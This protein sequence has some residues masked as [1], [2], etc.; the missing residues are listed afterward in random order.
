MGNQGFSQRGTSLALSL[1]VHE[2]KKLL[3]YRQVLGSCSPLGY[4]W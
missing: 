4:Y 2:R 3:F 1:H